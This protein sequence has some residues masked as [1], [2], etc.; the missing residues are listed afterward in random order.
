MAG[1]DLSRPPGTATDLVLVEREGDASAGRARF[2]AVPAPAYF[3]GHFPGHPVLPAVAQL[4][5]VRQALTRLLGHET[6]IVVVERLRC[7]RPVLPG[8]TLTLDLYWS[9]ACARV[10]FVLS[11]ST[12]RVSDGVLVCEALIERDVSD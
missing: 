12:D 2:T 9:D 5:I 10:R 11:L 4:A 6:A 8:E 3:E 1:A 7:A